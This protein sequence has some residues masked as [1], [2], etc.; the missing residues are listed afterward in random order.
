MMSKDILAEEVSTYFQA[1]GSLSSD[2]K[3]YVERSADK[4]IIDVIK[5]SRFCYVLSA[6]QMGKS[7]LKIKT[8]D[9]LKE[10]DW[11]CAGVE[12]SQIG[13]KAKT[14]QWYFTF[15]YEIA[16]A[17]GVLDKF[18]DW[19]ENNKK[20]TAV[21]RMGRF[22]DEVLIKHAEGTDNIAIFIDEIDSLLTINQEDFSVSDFFAALRATFNKSAESDK[23]G[24]SRLHFCIMGVASPDQLIDSNTRTPFNVGVG[25]KLTPIPLKNNEAFL[26]GLEGLG[27]PPED[28]LVEVE[29]W[30]GGQPYLSQRICYELT[31][32]NTDAV[33]Q[34]VRELYI[35]SHK[36]NSDPNLSNIQ[37]RIYDNEKNISGLLRVYRK[38]LAGEEVELD[39][40][41][42]AHIFLQ[43]SGLVREEN[44]KL[45]VF[46]NIYREIFD[47]NWAATAWT[48]IHGEKSFTQDMNLWMTQSKDPKLLLRGSKLKEANKWAGVAKH[49]QVDELEYLASSREAEEKRRRNILIWST[50][51]L[52]CALII[53]GLFI[54]S[55]RREN[56][57]ITNQKEKISKE[58]AVAEKER[59]LIRERIIEIRYQNDSLKVVAEDAE[60]DL[61]QTMADVNEIF[62]NNDQK[63]IVLNR[64]RQDSF[65]LANEVEVTKKETFTL[66]AKYFELQ[67]SSNNIRVASKNLINRLNLLID[68]T[69][70]G[71]KNIFAGLE[72][73]IANWSKTGISNPDEF[74]FTYNR[75]AEVLKEINDFN[76]QLIEH[77]QKKLQASTKTKEE[78]IRVTYLM[79]LMG[80]TGEAEELIKEF[81]ELLD[82][83]TVTY[84]PQANVHNWL[85]VEPKSSEMKAWVNKLE[86]YYIPTNSFVQP[87]KFV[88][89]GRR[90][91]LNDKKVPSQ[92]LRGVSKELVVKLDPYELG[93]TEVT[94]NQ[95]YLYLLDTNKGKRDLSVN[96]EN[97]ELPITNITYYDAVEYCNWLSKK[98]GLSQAY[99]KT[100]KG[101]SV[102]LAS[103]G[104]R[105]P[106][107]AEWEF[108]A[109]GGQNGID[110]DGYPKY[111]WS[112]FNERS[113]AP[114]YANVKKENG[115][116][117]DLIS[118]VPEEV[119][120]NPLGLYHMSGNVWEWVEDYYS[121]HSYTQF[122]NVEFVSNPIFTKQLPEEKTL[123]KVVRGGSFD[124]PL[125]RSYIFVRG[126]QPP[127]EKATNTGFR[128]ARSVH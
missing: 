71:Q 101:Y 122:G 86:E 46:N 19:W 124:N 67:D 50:V 109:A 92:S 41:D 42:K 35:S 1:G 52:I 32:R 91:I 70:A 15:C 120:P 68:S 37:N 45:K 76:H 75:T 53:S 65:Q 127:N 74:E 125:E 63:N 39:N 85:L 23:K 33:E 106:T 18:E 94:R 51:S 43:L 100:P 59:E 36:L 22:W 8:I 9:T 30:T 118:K 2:T 110:K 104:Y 79:H 73:K 13:T 17:V 54:N 27:T 38:I 55:I 80:Q 4:E 78:V 115:K 28:I 5:R 61:V 6:R 26:E 24:L 96:L 88:L 72:E 64:L 84:R 95:F 11:K 126:A 114:M 47:E 49:L 112:G 29:Y 14:D 16:D 25:V 10:Q 97:G 48:E 77:N 62:R 113:L 40:K 12:I 83:E 60:Q 107:E 93:K 119:K 111:R 3:V 58:L 99:V 81:N 103:N 21:A 69:V 87:R 90:T 31:I 34:V 105:L 123:G 98:E 121:D 7:S 116:L 117:Q 102:N 20:I 128:V 66:A 108:A 44:G 57:D 82:S 56:F 89:G